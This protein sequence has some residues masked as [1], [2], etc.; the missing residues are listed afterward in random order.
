LKQVLPGITLNEINE[1]SEKNAGN[2]KCFCPG[3]G[4][5]KRKDKLP[6]D[7]EL[8][9]QIIAASKQQV[10]PYEE[11]AVASSLVEGSMSAGKDSFR[12]KK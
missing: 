7:D 12:N 10:K 3:Y 8:E 4:P 2:D 1:V 5:H 6:S 9:K 11:K